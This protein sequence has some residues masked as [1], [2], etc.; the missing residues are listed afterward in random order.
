MTS[1]IGCNTC[2]LQIHD[3]FYLECSKL[4]CLK[5]Y[6]LKCLNIEIELFHAFTNDYKK[7]WVCS[8]CTQ[9]PNKSFITVCNTSLATPDNNNI[10]MQRGNQLRYHTSSPL[11]TDSVL[12]EHLTQ[13]RSEMNSRFDIQANVIAILQKQ[14]SDTNNKLDAVLT[15]LSSLEEKQ[16]IKIGTRANISKTGCDTSRSLEST[17][18]INKPLQEANKS[19]AITEILGVNSFAATK[20]TTA[21]S[22]ASPIKI[23]STCAPLFKDKGDCEGQGIGKEVCIDERDNNNINVTHNNEQ[24][25]ERRS[26]RVGSNKDSLILKGMERKKYLH[27]WRL[28]PETSLETLTKYVKNVCGPDALIKIDKIKH[29]T[30]RD[31]ASFIIG[32]PENLFNTLN[33]PEIWP[34]NAEFSEWIWFRK[35]AKKPKSS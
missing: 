35:A 17:Y 24:S 27:V 18:Y 8:E 9:S 14:L 20:P 2:G 32:V 19:D 26:V 33:Q 11:S 12:L 1:K 4:K 31:Y 30:A 15:I 3:E 5:R 29:K 34:V 23:A 6:D 16:C 21:T 10:N 25:S 28:H 22:S 7:S 13:L